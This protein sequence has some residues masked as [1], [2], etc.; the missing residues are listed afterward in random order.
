MPMKSEKQ[1][2]FL[3]AKYPALA[4]TFEAETPKDAKL[5]MFAKKKKTKS[6]F[7]SIKTSY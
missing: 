6:R 1:R 4:K 3:H 5:P 2:K 7:S